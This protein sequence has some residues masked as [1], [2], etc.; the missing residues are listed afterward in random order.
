MKSDLKVVWTFAV[1]VSV[2]LVLGLHVVGCRRPLPPNPSL[3]TWRSSKATPDERA[4]AVKQL[5]KPGTV[6]GKVEELLGPGG[7]WMRIRGP[8]FVLKDGDA[9]PSDQ[10]VEFWNLSY[11]FGDATVALSFTNSRGNSQSQCRFH[12][13]GVLPRPP[14][15]VPGR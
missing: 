9:I 14:A 2:W 6:A 1:A 11:R 12:S 13:V 10:Y 3:A 15:G 4:E 5:I 7:E 8:A